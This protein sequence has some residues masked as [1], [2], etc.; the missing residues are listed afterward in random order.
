[1]HHNESPGDYCSQLNGSVLGLC[2][3][4]NHQTACETFMEMDIS[5]SVIGNQ[6]WIN[7]PQTMIMYYWTYGMRK[8]DWVMSLQHGVSPCMRPCWW[9]RRESAQSESCTCVVNLSQ[10]M[11]WLLAPLLPGKAMALG[12]GRQTEASEDVWLLRQGLSH[13]KKGNSF[14]P[15]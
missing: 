8:G 5:I 12:S 2:R 10:N 9:Q 15:V 13:C 7:R 14:P 4:R 1:M 3:R 6:N 11:L